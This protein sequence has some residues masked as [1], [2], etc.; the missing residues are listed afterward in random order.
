MDYSFIN[1]AFQMQEEL[2]IQ[3]SVEDELLYGTDEDLEVL[4][5]LEF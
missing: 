5:D 3:Q 1:I 2:A 4:V